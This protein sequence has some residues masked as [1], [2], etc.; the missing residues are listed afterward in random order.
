VLV[1]VLVLVVA[2]KYLEDEAKHGKEAAQQARP[3]NI[4]GA[5]IFG[6]VVIV[7]ITT[8]RPVQEIIMALS[9]LILA[10]VLWLI[11][12][13]ARR[14]RSRD[15]VVILDLDITYT[16]S[17]WIIVPTVLVGSLAIVATLVDPQ[18]R[19]LHFTQGL[20]WL[21]IGVAFLILNRTKTII[22]DSGVYT[23]YASISWSQIQ[24]FKWKETKG[25]T[26]RLIIEAH[27]RLPL[28]G[29]TWIPIPREQQDAVNTLLLQHTSLPE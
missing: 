20:L 8:G 11:I 7:F 25:D 13:R 9:Y 23:G 3:A 17:S 29:S 28:L 21:S 24:S 27:S 12:V 4:I 18:Q 19:L 22:T 14:N 6:D 16:M 15:A 1:P 2:Q 10:S 26:I 5:V